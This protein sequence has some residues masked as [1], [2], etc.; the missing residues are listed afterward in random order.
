MKILIVTDP[1]ANDSIH[2]YR[3]KCSL[4]LRN[5][6]YAAL[7]E[8]DLESGLC[9]L[10]DIVKALDNECNYWLNETYCFEVISV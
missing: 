9:V 8:L 10:D 1:G 4:N 6:V 7:Y 3:A 2:V 5:D